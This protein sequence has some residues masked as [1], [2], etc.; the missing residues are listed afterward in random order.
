MDPFPG[1]DAT[2]DRMIEHAADPLDDRKPE[3]E[4]AGDACAAFE[5]VELVEDRLLLG[6]GNADA[7]V[8]D[9]D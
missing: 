7:G 9:L 8:V 6:G 3:A 5:P 2:G 4:P 1:T